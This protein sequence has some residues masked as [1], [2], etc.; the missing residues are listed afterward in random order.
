MRVAGAD[1]AGVDLTGN[2]FVMADCVGANFNEAVLERTDFTAAAL[3]DGAQYARFR[4]ANLSQANFISAMLVRADFQDAVLFG[5][6][7]YSSRGDRREVALVRGANFA[8]V[9]GLTG[10]AFA[11]LDLT[12][13][14]LPERYAEGAL[15]AIETVSIQSRNL[16]AMALVASAYVFLTVFNIN[17]DASIREIELPVLEVAVPAA[18]FTL[19]AS[20]L[21]L[22]IYAYIH[23]K[24]RTVWAELRRL[25]SRFP[26]GRP[27][28]RHIY[29]FIVTALATPVRG[30]P[31]RVAGD[32]FKISTWLGTFFEVLGAVIAG[33][34][35]V[36]G[37]LAGLLYFE[38][39]KRNAQAQLNGA[40]FGSIWPAA[41]TSI[42]ALS[43]G[44][45]VWSAWVLVSDL[46]S[47]RVNLE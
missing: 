37:I 6:R 28:G 9:T 3:C 47:R 33:W 20:V 45:M 27:A 25:P 14:K 31:G 44:V 17:A 22:F 41:E 46:R 2:G 43:V 1:L 13:A 35:L 10:T 8:G 30:K 32:R 16:L 36:P 40:E 34:L 5:A 15:S 39:Q 24:L 19:T 12:D 11:N 7:F 38:V 29:P 42:L 4:R 21:L 26:D 18:S 23:T